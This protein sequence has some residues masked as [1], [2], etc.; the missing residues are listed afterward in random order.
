MN[1]AQSR[2]LQQKDHIGKNLPINQQIY[3]PHGTK[4]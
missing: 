1:Q 2:T 3:R 4:D